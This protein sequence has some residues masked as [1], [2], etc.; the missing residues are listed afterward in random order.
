MPFFSSETQTSNVMS[1]KIHQRVRY[2]TVK[3]HA[4]EAT[5]RLLAM[6]III[7]F[8]ATYSFVLNAIN[9]M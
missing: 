6:A 9:A 7:Q 3:R 5:D 1:G 8:S 2:E 4:V